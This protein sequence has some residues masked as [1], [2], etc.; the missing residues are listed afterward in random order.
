MPLAAR[1]GDPAYRFPRGPP[2]VVERELSG[3]A[4]I[5]TYTVEHAGGS[6]TRLIAVCETP[7]GGRTLGEMSDAEA[8]ADAMVD[9][10]VG[11]AV[12]LDD[13]RIVP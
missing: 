7:D 4:H 8:M 10:W 3:P 6:P 9:E 12:V 2:L 13:S 5:V 11:R 1:R